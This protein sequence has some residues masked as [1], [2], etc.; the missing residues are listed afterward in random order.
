MN[1]QHSITRGEVCP[2]SYW[3][4]ASREQLSET[5]ASRKH[6]QALPTEAEL[7]KAFGVRLK[8]TTMQHGGSK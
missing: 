6:Q 3:V 1:L 4:G 5:S 2:D 8:T 7:A